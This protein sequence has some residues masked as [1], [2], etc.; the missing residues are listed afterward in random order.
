VVLS[1]GLLDMLAEVGAEGNV[2]D[3]HEDGVAPVVAHQ[4]ITDATG[5]GVGIRAAVGND[6]L[7]HND[8]PA[9]V[10]RPLQWHA[11]YKRITAAR[12]P[13]PLSVQN[14]LTT[15]RNT[16]PIIRSVGTSL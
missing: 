3:V 11:C 8:T 14:G 2:V 12:I 1:D 9:K 10:R 5:N 13:N 6:D 16:T 4:A 7:R 15:T